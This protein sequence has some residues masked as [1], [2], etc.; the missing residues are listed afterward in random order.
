MNTK[1]K[2]IVGPH[3][4]IFHQND[5]VA[6][7]LISILHGRNVKVI[8]THDPLLLATCDYVVDVGGGEFDHDMPGGNGVREG[9][10][11]SSHYASAGLVWKKYSDDILNFAVALMNLFTMQ[12][13]KSLK[14]S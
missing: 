3:S 4:G 11:P 10:I 7:A 9:A 6:V 5:V 12:L 14:I 8:R 13:R 1:E 2:I